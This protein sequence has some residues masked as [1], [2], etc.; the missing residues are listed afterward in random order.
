MDDFNGDE[1]IQNAFFFVCF[2][3]I[4]I[5]HKSWGSMNG[6]QFLWLSWFP[7]KNQVC[8]Y[9]CNTV[10]LG[11]YVSFTKHVSYQ[12][13]YHDFFLNLVKT[14]NNFGGK[15]K[16]VFR[17][18]SYHGG[19][20][21]LYESWVE[22]GRPVVKPTVRLTGRQHGWQQNRVKILPEGSTNQAYSHWS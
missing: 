8:L 21:R 16:I 4:K 3:H 19:T 20:R 14:L 1:A 22:P 15:F 9:L 10:Y 11:K 2:I 13:T 6:T 18:L 12:S 5:C 17:Y 7:A